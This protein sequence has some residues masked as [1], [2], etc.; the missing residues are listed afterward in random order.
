MAQ[1]IEHDIRFLTE[2]EKLIKS[3]LFDRYD[4]SKVEGLHQMIRD[5]KN[6]LILEEQENLKT[7]NSNP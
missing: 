2:M 5:W 6:E 4:E 1:D 3:L 7:T